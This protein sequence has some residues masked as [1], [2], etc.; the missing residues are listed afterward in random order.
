MEYNFESDIK[1]LTGDKALRKSITEIGNLGCRRIMLV[2]DDIS[3]RV[4]QLGDM[5]HQ[6]NKELNIVASYKRVGEIATVSACEKVLRDYKTNDCDSILVVG[7][8]SAIAVAKAV[9]IMLKDDISFMSN[10][11]TCSVNNISSIRIPLIVVPTNLASGT[12][13]SNFVRVYDTENNEIFEFNTPF[14]Q[15]NLIVLDPIMTDTMPPKVFAASGLYSLAMAVLSLSKTNDVKPLAKVYAVTAINLLTENMKKAILQNAAKQYRFKLLLATV[16][17]GY[18]YWQTPKDILSE[19]ADRISDRYRISYRNIFCILFLKYVNM[20]KWPQEFDM[21]ALITLIGDNDYLEVNDETS[22]SDKINREN[23]IRDSV[24]GYYARTKKYVN[25]VDR[26]RDL[27]VNQSD[28]TDIASSVISMHKEE[29]EEYT[30]S[31][32]T[33]LLEE[34][35]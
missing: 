14:A 23:V 25:Y 10:Y 21:N 6:F 4:G 7:R 26:L 24:N 19:L 17:A 1:F 35:F 2:C 34:A 30:Y 27:G 16:L 29:S 20:H 12:E 32:I 8:K 31:F 15:T 9:K 33:Q 28:F 3:E 11:R 13:A 18:A 22:D 5:L